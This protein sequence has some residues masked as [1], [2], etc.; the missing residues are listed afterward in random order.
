MHNLLQDFRYGFRTLFKNPSFTLAVVL[1][2]AVGIGANTLVFSVVEA[3]LFRPLPYRDPRNLA[4]VW[5]T[6]PS[7]GQ[8]QV[9]YDDFSD[10]RSQARSF[11]QLA[12]Y[13]FKG[14]DVRVLLTGGEPQ[15]LQ[16]TVVSQNLLSTLGV[17]PQLGR[18][19]AAGEDQPGHDHVTLLSD[20]LWR[21]TFHADPTIIGRSITLGSDSFI[22]IGVMPRE[23][24]LPSWAQVWL[25]LSQISIA[26]KQQGRVFHPLEVVGRLKLGVTVVQAQSELATITHRLQA[27]Y[28]ATNKTIG[29]Q[30]I[31]LE[32][33]VVGNVRP[34]LILLLSVVSFVLLIACINVAN[35]LLARA[36]SRQ[37]EF[38][39]RSALGASRWRVSSQLICESLVI[40]GV[41]AILGLLLTSLL[42]PVLRVWL[43]NMLPRAEGLSIDTS[44]L[45]F[46]VGLTLATG[47]VFGMLPA[48]P[49]W[50]LDVFGVLKTRGTEDSSPR[51]RAFRSLLVIGEVSLALVVLVTAGLLIRSLGQLLNSDVGFQPEQTVTMRLSLPATKYAKQ[52]QID[53]FFQQLVA[54]LKSS[55]QVQSAGVINN[56]P[57][58]NQLAGQSRFAVQGQPAPAA[59]QFPVTQIRT[60]SPEYLA[61]LKIPLVAG[62][63][64]VETDLPNNVVVVNQAFQR[65]YLSNG[66]P[67]LQKILFG[68]MS[69]SPQSFQVL[70]VV[71]NVKD[72]ALDASPEP[73]VYFPGYS[74]NANV[75]VR[76]N[77][78]ALTAASLLRSEVAALDHDQ[79]IESIQTLEQVMSNSVAKQ[80]LSALVMVA[81]SSISLVLAAI[82]I[83]GVMAYLVVQRKREI[84]IR[85]ALGAGR[86]DILKLVVGQG[87]RLAIFGAVA[88]C[89]LALVVGRA[90]TNMLYN[91][92]GTDPA[93]FG[94]VGGLLVSVAFIAIYLPSRR[95]ANADPMTALKYE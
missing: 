7:F 95:A 18:D 77:G 76:T 36:L 32:Q 84:A 13:S 6:H 69:K 14:E 8:L 37:K 5:E 28:P 51:T 20:S 62:R 35:L 86:R 15:Q 63:W 60:A 31:S 10:L 61:T 91:V 25:P 9:A 2:L 64:F 57:L 71:G 44:I 11:E 53:S 26:Y 56:L 47:I 52:E 38:A 33:Q 30:A 78:S 29:F 81:F 66:D 87:M 16:A 19:F 88:G 41:G 54:R 23:G 72:V 40:S 24:Q 65:R 73:Q 93:T 21:N 45:L 4:M 80:R 3:V 82:G 50:K 92:R 39:V 49:A 70:G 59:G 83:Y 94:I 90:I 43:S 27:A 46:T 22:V 42:L 85:V 58:E 55:S 74:N 75:I 17:Q 48:I 12:A 68:V 67:T 34:V 79:P 89:V 1:T